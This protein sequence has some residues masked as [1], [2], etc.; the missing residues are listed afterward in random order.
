MTSGSL[1]SNPFVAAGMIEDS[2]LFVGR[3]HEL[4]AIASRMSGVQPTSINLVGEKRIGKSSLLYHFFLTWEQRVSDPNRYVVI[5][6]SLQN[7]QC[8]REENFYQAIA[9]Q[10]LHFPRV[11]NNLA[12]REDYPLIKSLATKILKKNAVIQRCLSMKTICFS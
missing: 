11:A 9:R 6:L 8:H 10:L 2:K 1:P 3:K 7:V 12:L 5:Y 4:R